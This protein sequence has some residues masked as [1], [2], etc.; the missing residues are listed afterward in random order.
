MSTQ[1]GSGYGLRR[2]CLSFV[3]VSAQSIAGI[4]PTSTLV[5]VISLVFASAGNGTWLAY[6]LATIGLMLVG[7]GINQFAKRSASP[8][9]FFVYI[10]QALGPSVGF[11]SGWSLL[12]AYILSSV[13]ALIGAS[14]FASVLL[15]M[16]HIT[17]HPLI[18]YA[19]GAALIW[20]VAYKDI[21]LSASLML[22]LEGVSIVLILILGILV[23]VNRSNLFDWPQIQLSGINFDGVR[24]GLILA[25]FSYVGYESATAIGEE[26]K[27]PL[28][29]VPRAV[30]LSPL[31]CGIFFMAYAYIEILGFRTLSVPFDKS[32]APINDLADSIGLPFIGVLIVF[33]AVVSLFACALASVN[34]SARIMFRM[35]GYGVLPKKLGAAHQQNQTPHYATTLTAVLMF[36]ISAVPVCIGISVL[37]AISA[38]ATMATFGFLLVYILISVAAPVYL[39]SLRELRAGHIL[40]AIVSI[41]FLLLPAIA[42]FY[43]LPAAPADKLP[44]YFGAYM[45]VGI[46]WLVWFRL[47]SPAVVERIRQDL[48]FGQAVASSGDVEAGV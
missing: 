34:A 36:F 24:L 39:R 22:V 16:M 42:T 23:L 13:A 12:L 35:G 43:P 25:I 38:M 11:I 28:V 26:A 40:V 30:L 21:R 27:R 2:R 15:A 46:V 1:R 45:L 17:V 47:T 5:L 44:I 41:L 4:S 7:L 20:Y 19:V 3:E 18:L 33:G 9:A 37:D 8:G 14:N 10:G 32:T 48:K 31:I 6:L 29:T